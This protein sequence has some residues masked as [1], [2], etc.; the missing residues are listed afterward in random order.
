MFVAVLLPIVLACPCPT[1]DATDTASRISTS[2][3]LVGRRRVCGVSVSVFLDFTLVQVV[4]V[5]FHA[6]LPFVQ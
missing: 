2:I 1:A 6:S 4:Y 3:L 5:S